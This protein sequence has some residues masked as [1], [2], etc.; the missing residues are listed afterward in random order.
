MHEWV[1]W[2]GTHFSA[3]QY[4]FWT[5]LQCLAWTGADIIIVF[6]LIRLANLARDY[7][8]TRK[9]R[10]P[11]GVLAATLPPIPFVVLAQ[12]GGLIFL[13]ELAITIPHF[14]LILYLLIV[15]FDFFKRSYH[16]LIRDT[17]G[18]S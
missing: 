14:L 12:S 18:G 5:R 6:A 13:L 1:L 9:H 3:Q 8:G 15:N 10:I 2:I 16:R 7:L 4:L 17:Q 11:Y